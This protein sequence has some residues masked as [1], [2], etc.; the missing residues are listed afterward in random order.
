M[1]KKIT[2]IGLVVRILDI[3]HKILNSIL[4]CSIVKLKNK[5]FMLLH[6]YVY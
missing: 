5:Y 3:M 1:I 4:I 6:Y 2:W